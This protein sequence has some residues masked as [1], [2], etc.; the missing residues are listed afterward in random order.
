VN[1][2]HPRLLECRLKDASGRIVDD[3]GELELCGPTVFSGYYRNAEATRLGFDG[4]WLKTGDVARRDALGRYLIVG[5]NKQAVM[6]GGFSVYLNEVEEA[7][8]AVQGVAEAAAVRCILAS[9]AED[10]G[11]I[12]R[13]AAGVALQDLDLLARLRDDLGPQRAPYR[14][15]ATSEHLPRAAQHKLDRKA[16]ANLWDTATGGTTATDVTGVR[17]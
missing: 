14:I 11:L 8:E 2:G 17:T 5:R 13:L 4:R 15:I 12:V 6:K 16:L 3:E 7:A 10:I 9:G 1:I